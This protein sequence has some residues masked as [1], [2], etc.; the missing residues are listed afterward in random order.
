[1]VDPRALRA[2]ADEALELHE[3]G[4]LAGA[5]AVCDRILADA[6]PLEPTD[7]VVRESVFT[8]RFQRGVLLGEQGDLAAAARAYGQAA[9]TPSDPEDPDQRHE[10]AMA[11]LNQ[12]ICLE[13]LGDPAGALGVYDRLL[14][15]LA[16][17]QDPVTVDQVVRARVNRAVVL[18]DL[19]RADE[20]LAAAAELE[21]EL[22]P[23]D[24]LEAEQLVMAARVRAAAL[25]ALD[26]REEAVR[27][28]EG[29]E[30]CRDE[31]PGARRQVADA[32]AERARLLQDLG[33]H[34]EAGEVRERAARYP[35]T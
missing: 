6:A 8:A 17:A 12:G 4:E 31:E 23:R 10:L 26:R 1:M 20:A 15:R 16:H 32:L 9:E 13:T 24:A 27:A 2:Q 11:L 7:Q 33:R 19:D 30:R 14:E 29:V 18:L 25:T 35:G 34:G 22:D 28:L 3:R 5:L 21:G